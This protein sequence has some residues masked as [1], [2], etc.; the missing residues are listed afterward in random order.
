LGGYVEL[1]LPA[2]YPPQ[3]TPA[4]WNAMVD[5]ANG[6]TVSG[7]T[8]QYPYSFIIRDNGGFYEAVDSHGII[9]YGG[10]GDIGVTDAIDAAEVI[11][12]AVE[13][14]P[15][16]KI[17]F[18]GDTVFHCKTPMDF[19]D[20]GPLMEGEGWGQY[21][22]T[23]HGSIISKEFNG[24]LLKFTYSDGAQPVFGIRDLAFIGT[25]ATYTGRGIE[26]TGLPNGW[27]IENTR[28]RDFADNCLYVHDTGKHWL[29]KCLFSA[30]D[31][32]VIW[33][34]HAADWRWWEV[35]ADWAR[36]SGY[37]AAN[38]N[39]LCTGEIIG[40]HFEGYYGLHIENSYIEMIGGRVTD[41]SIQGIRL[42]GCSSGS[43]LIGV[44]VLN[45]N[46]D[47]SAAGY[48]IYNWE[49]D[50]VQ[51]IGCRIEDTNVISLMRYGIY[52]SGGNHVGNRY[53]G[54]HIKGWLSDAFNKAWLDT[55][56]FGNSKITEVWGAA[57]L[58]GDGGVI[59]HGLGVAPEVALI[60]PSV[61]GEFV[62]VTSMD[63][64]HV[65]VAIK[66][67]DGSAG[68]AQTLYYHIYRWTMQ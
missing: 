18:A 7:A 19:T 10:S 6:M 39:Q 21:P 1:A 45:C 43:R 9:T 56:I 31:T 3:V 14:A 12:K 67:H 63:N 52:E 22:F 44:S 42:V 25:K 33:Y 36:G 53:I 28:V 62:T 59:T 13:A 66:K 23:A 17:T 68:T 20:V 50:N 51:V 49:S 41:C 27:F 57:P 29:I 8:I 5:A 37:S 4:S 34:D 55:Q 54:N 11:T 58:I 26:V 24:T 61:S 64:L 32:D 40:G 47:N 30:S 15:Y 2:K 60:T 65:T 38:I 35:E 46:A 48:G 16:G